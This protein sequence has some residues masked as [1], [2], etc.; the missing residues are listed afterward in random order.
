[1]LEADRIV[2]TTCPFC[3]VGCNLE[4]SLDENGRPFLSVNK[5][6]TTQ[7]LPDISISHSASMAAAMPTGPAPTMTT[8]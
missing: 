5:E 4:L 1:M 7:S 6:N 3:G 2:P 8:G